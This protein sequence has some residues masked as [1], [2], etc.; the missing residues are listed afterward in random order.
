[1]LEDLLQRC[2]EL[3]DFAVVVAT[4]TKDVGTVFVSRGVKDKF[5]VC[6]QVQQHTQQR[7]VRTQDDLIGDLLL[8][9]YVLRRAKPQ[10]QRIGERRAVG[11]AAERQA[12]SVIDAADDVPLNCD[13]GCDKVAQFLMG[14]GVQ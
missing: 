6:G 11:N 5:N 14:R 8:T 13:D 3:S 4:T 2:S 9:A 1:M 12:H 10:L 7:V